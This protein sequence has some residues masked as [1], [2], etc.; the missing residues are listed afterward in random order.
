[1]I[2]LIGV[3]YLIAGVITAIVAIRFFDEDFEDIALLIVIAWPFM[4][5]I[6]VLVGLGMMLNGTIVKLANIGK[7]ADR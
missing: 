7:H 2:W 4:L 3:G 1:M 5:L 6:A